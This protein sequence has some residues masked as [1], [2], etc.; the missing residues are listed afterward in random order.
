MR[1]GG[2][3]WHPFTVM[4]ARPLLASLAVAFAVG[5]CS[6]APSAPA[7]DPSELRPGGATT[8]SL[9]PFPSLE[10]P[11]ANLPQ[12]L[13]PDFYAGR[14]LARQPWVKAPTLTDARDGLGPLYNARTCL[15]CHAKGGRGFWPDD[16][17]QPLVRGLVRLSVPGEDVKRG[18]VPEPTYGLQ[19]QS[20]STALSHQLRGHVDAS[21]PASIPPEATP[22][23]RWREQEFRYPDGRV[24]TLRKPELQLRDLGYGPMHP[25]VLRSIRVAPPFHG[26]GL[27]ELIKAEDIGALADPDDADGDGISGRLNRVWDFRRGRLVPGRFG[28]KANRAS[29]EITV[30]G[31][32]A[33]D[34]GIASRL[35]P[36]QPCTDA[37]E[38]CQRGPHGLDADGVEISDA[39][40]GLVVDYVRNLGVPG[41]RSANT[42]RVL[43]GRALFR[44]TG[45]ATCHHPRFETGKSAEHPH[46]ADQTLWPYSDFLLHDMGPGLADGRPD[47]EATGSEWRTAPLWGAGLTKRVVG[48]ESYLHDGRA[49]SLEEAVLW[50]AGEARGARDRFAQLPKPSRRQLLAFVASL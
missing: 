31:A 8:T 37:Q 46:L 15:A 6:R 35:F 3:R 28:Y 50:H 5:G 2:A 43:A 40:L 41:R 25:E 48:T 16:P 32:F 13:K 26:M 30:A 23:V 34:I 36:R 33:D 9:V 12:A 27:V 49:R 47:Y 45:C 38:A 7:A 4:H 1:V 22:H 17:D 19:L 21:L 24:V 14:A 39:L 11:A 18:A 20:Q 10:S 44:A 42:K 29:L